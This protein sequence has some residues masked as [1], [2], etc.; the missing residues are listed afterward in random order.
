MSTYIGIDVGGTNLKA[1]LVS[2]DGALLA[3]K[4]VP[5]GA[6]ESAEAFARTLVCLARELLAERGTR[7]SDIKAIGIGIPGLVDSARGIISY[8]PNIPMREVPIAALMQR[9]WDIPIYL[10]NDANCAALGEYHAGA[11]RGARSLVVVTLGTGIGSGIVIDGAIYEGFNGAGGEAGHM[12]IVMD[13]ELCN[14]GRRGCWERYASATALVRL[15]KRVMDENPESIMWKLCGEGEK[16]HVSGKTAFAAARMGDAAAQAACGEYLDYL[17]AGVANLVNILQPEMVA[18]GGGVS[19]E[20]DGSLLLPLRE[21]V[22]RF[23][24]AR[25]GAKQRTSIVKAQ[26]GNDAGIIGAALLHRSAKMK[27]ERNG[28]V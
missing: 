22:A 3:T 21:R 17:A 10:G 16:F 7:E 18:I 24:M 4:K 14:C 27:E 28:V 9:E 20:E 19:N 23:D 12:A 8:T 2:E 15:T 26:L 13:G 25:N 5:L 6:W 1:G 11:G